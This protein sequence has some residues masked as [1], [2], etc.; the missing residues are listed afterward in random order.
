MLDTAG[1]PQDLIAGNPDALDTTIEGLMT[2]G[3]SAQDAG[4]GLSR[5][6]T[7]EG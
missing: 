7:G 3:V 1:V 4:S 2:L 6:C 5:L